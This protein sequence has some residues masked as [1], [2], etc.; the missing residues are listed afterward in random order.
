MTCRAGRASRSAWTSVK[1]LSK[2]DWV[3]K[4]LSALSTGLVGREGYEGEGDAERL[5]GADR[6][7]RLGGA[8]RATRL[9]CAERGKE[10]EDGDEKTGVRVD[11][12]S[13]RIMVR[14]MMRPSRSWTW[15]CA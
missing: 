4:Q 3:R 5:D 6:A 11:V 7:T 12:W 15:T 2:A 8:E 14:V 13:G 1:S 9:D 10:V